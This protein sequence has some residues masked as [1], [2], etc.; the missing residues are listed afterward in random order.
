M[1]KKTTNNKQTNK[2]QKRRE[3]TEPTFNIGNYQFK[4]EITLASNGGLCL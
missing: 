2:Q 4:K 3:E 1:E